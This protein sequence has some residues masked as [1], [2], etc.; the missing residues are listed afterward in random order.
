MVTN[1]SDSRQAYV[2]NLGLRQSYGS[3][4]SKMDAIAPRENG[5]YRITV[6]KVMIPVAAKLWVKSHYL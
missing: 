1:P 2:S 4:H 6:G 3:T 5:E